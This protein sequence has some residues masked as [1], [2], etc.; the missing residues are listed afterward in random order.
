MKSTVIDAA[1]GTSAV[2]SPWWLQHLETTLGLI[3][4]IGG[5][6]LLVLRIAI[7]WRNWRRPQSEKN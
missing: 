2:A 6:I 5:V 4:L 3:M 7:A 1:L